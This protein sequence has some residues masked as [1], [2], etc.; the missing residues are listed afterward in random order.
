[1]H[2]ELNHIELVN[3]EPIHHFE[4]TK[5]GFTAFIDYLKRGDKVFLVHTDVPV[6]LEGK[7]VAGKLVEKVFQYLEEH[8]LNMVP[9][10]S[11]VNH[12]LQK[13]PEWG[14]LQTEK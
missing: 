6:E 8:N 3:N 12:Y 9:L 2:E 14:K 7:G 1:M 11:Y 4:L 10:C 5:D 13:H